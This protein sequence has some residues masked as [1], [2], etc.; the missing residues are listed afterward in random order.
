FAVPGGPRNHHSTPL[1][2][3]AAV[4]E[5]LKRQPVF[6][7]YAFGSYLIFL[8][9]PPSIDSRAELYGPAFLDDY[10]RAASDRCVLADALKRVGAAWT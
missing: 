5:D 7:D 4:P 1:A 9:I 3:I 2:A 6:N 10:N 8:G